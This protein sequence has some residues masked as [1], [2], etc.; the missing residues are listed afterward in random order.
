MDEAKLQEILDDAQ[1]AQVLRIGA[2]EHGAA[3]PDD[4]SAWDDE[5]T[6]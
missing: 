6:L 3:Q 5:V 1:I 4:D 2:S